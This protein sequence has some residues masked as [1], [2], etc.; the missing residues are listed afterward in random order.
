MN[1]IQQIKMLKAS[2]GCKRMAAAKINWGEVFMIPAK[3]ASVSPRMSQI[4]INKPSKLTS[5]R[6]KPIALRLDSQLEG[7]LVIL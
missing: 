2:A 1:G 6:T 3:K 7:R 5:D 4:P